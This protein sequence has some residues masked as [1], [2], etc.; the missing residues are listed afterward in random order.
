MQNCM[1]DELVFAGCETN[2]VG[3]LKK[4][5]SLKLGAVSNGCYVRL[6]PIAWSWF[7]LGAHVTMDRIKA[8]ELLGFGEKLTPL[9]MVVCEPC[10]EFI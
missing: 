1:F 7:Y 5:Q 2:D 9:Y 4:A 10:S 8:E 3:V 6:K